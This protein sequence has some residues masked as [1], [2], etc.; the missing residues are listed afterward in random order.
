MG[1]IPACHPGG[2]GRPLGSRR[3]MGLFRN[4]GQLLKRRSVRPV[5]RLWALTQITSWRELKRKKS[6]QP[7]RTTS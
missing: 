1:L 6:G 5:C 7:L 3:R 2:S 4:F